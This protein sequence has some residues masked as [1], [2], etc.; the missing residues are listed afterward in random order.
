MRKTSCKNRNG[1]TLAEAMMATV[2]L[3]VAAGGVLLPF[4]VG[5]SVRTEGIHRTLAAKLAADL[6]EQIVNTPFDQIITSF[7]GY[8]ELEGQV[9]D[10][11]GTVF[12]D[13][14][15]SL[16][17][18]DASCTYVPVPQESGSGESKYILTTVRVYYNG[19]ELAVIKRLITR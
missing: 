3:A 9:K 5:M 16:F 13:D 14:I 7:D 11:A 6:T 15:Y 1:F 10:A 2:V 12:T 17:S 4:T 8:T 19:A 18:R